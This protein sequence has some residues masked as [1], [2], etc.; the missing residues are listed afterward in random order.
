[1][2]CMCFAGGKLWHR[3]YPSEPQ[4]HLD[5]Q[6]FCFQKELSTAMSSWVC[7]LIIYCYM[8]YFEQGSVD[9]TIFSRVIDKRP[10]QGSNF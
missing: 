9:C 3:D 5:D 7:V 2:Y 4:K 6:F 8:G 1:M 10:K